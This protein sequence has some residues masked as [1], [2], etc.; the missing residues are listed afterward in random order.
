MQ[1]N[2]DDPLMLMGLCIAA[3]A[4][5]GAQIVE[6]YGRQLEVPTL[7]ILLAPTILWTVDTSYP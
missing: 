3:Q 7:D 5:V 2:N 6:P 4:A 1:I